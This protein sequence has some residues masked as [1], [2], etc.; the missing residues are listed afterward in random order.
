M[1]ISVDKLLKTVSVF[2]GAYPHGSAQRKIPKLSTGWPAAI[3]WG[4][5]GEELPPHQNEERAAH[6][7]EDIGIARGVTPAVV[8][9]SDATMRRWNYKECVTH[10]PVAFA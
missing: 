4:V 6:R 2:S 10:R 8:C 5:W 3:F 1:G 7:F 9:G